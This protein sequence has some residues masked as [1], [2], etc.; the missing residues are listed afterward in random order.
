[1]TQ[2]P[3]DFCYANIPNEKPEKTESDENPNDMHPEALC[4][5]CD[6]EEVF[7]YQFPAKKQEENSLSYPYL[8]LGSY[9]G[10]LYAFAPRVAE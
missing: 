1:L 9:G 2:I 10:H 4:G 6:H 3:Y 7:S 5:D 8:R